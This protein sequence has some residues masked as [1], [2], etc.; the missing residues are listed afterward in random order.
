MSM[1]DFFGKLKAIID[2]LAI[3][4]NH[5][6]SIDFITHLISGLCQP[7]YLVVV[8]IEANLAKMTINEAYSMLLTH[9]ARLEANQ[10]SASKEVK[11]N[12]AANVAQTGFGNK[13]G[14]Q[15][16]NSW[17]KNIGNGT[18]GRGGYGRGF[19]QSQGRGNWTGM[20]FGA[21]NYQGR[22]GYIAGNGNNFDSYGY[23]AGN[24]NFAKAAGFNNGNSGF[25]LNNAAT[26][27]I[28][29]IC[30][31]PKHTAAECKNRFNRDFI[32]SY[33]NYGFSS[34]QQ[35]AP[36]AAFLAT[37]EG[38]MAN[39]GWYIDSEAAHHLTNNL[40]SLNLGIEYS[41][42]EKGCASGSRDC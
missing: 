7:Y 40:Q 39:Q 38:D 32:P 23:S 37:S 29:Q 19:N 1:T 11:L 34:S 20:Q 36:K 21:G 42:Q 22:G 27:V 5:V 13:S 31:K 16:N 24:N 8:Y 4:G 18:G 12:Y 10:L 28:C 15:F 25:N 33:P 3:A 14:G 41:G 9:E 17:Q 2:Y 26:A 35:P 30:F 6:S